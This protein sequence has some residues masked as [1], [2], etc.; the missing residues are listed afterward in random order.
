[1]L[2]D[3]KRHFCGA[4]REFQVFILVRDTNP[5]S[6][7]YIKQNGYAPKRIDCKAK[8]AETGE[9]AGLVVDPTKLGTSAFSEQKLEKALREWENFVPVLKSG[10]GYDV[11]SDG[12]VTFQGKSIHGDYD[13]KDIVRAEQPFRNLG[14]I[15]YLYD[16]PHSTCSKYYLVRDYVNHRIEWPMIQHGPEAQYKGH[17]DEMI[18]MF[19]P[20]GRYEPLASLSD[21]NRVYRDVFNGRKPLEIK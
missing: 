19:Y 13:L 18:H 8:T 4:A 2:A 5:A 15:G 11:E 9:F 12:R 1:M 16:Q 21:L 20:S 14:S 6:L 17:S 10:V 7:Q 3:H